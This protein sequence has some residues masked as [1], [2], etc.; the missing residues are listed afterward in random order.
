M[1]RKTAQPANIKVTGELP[2]KSPSGRKYLVRNP[3]DHDFVT[4]PKVEGKIVQ[5]GTIEIEGKDR[6]FIVVETEKGLSRVFES[7]A[8]EDLFSQAK[9]GRFCSI[10]YQGEKDLGSGRTFQ[11]FSVEVWEE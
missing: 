10:V 11:K 6:P 4:T 7:K 5:V 3:T 9:V 2:M 8:K 1:A